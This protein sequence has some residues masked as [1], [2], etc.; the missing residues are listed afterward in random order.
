VQVA[1]LA[2]RQ[3]GVVSRAQL[4]EMGLARG[5][6]DGRLA[7]GRLHPMHGVYLVG[8]RALPPLAREA[9]ALLAVGAAGALSHHAAA[10]LHQFGPTPHPPLDVAVPVSHRGRRRDL[11]LRRLSLDAEEVTRR[12]GLRATT[13]ARTLL[14]L[15]AVTTPGRLERLMAEAFAQRHT[16]R[17]A[18]L[19]AMDG[20]PGA[21]GTRVLRNLLQAGPADTRSHPERR[22][23]QILRASRLPAPE[24]NVRLGPWTP[25]FL[26]RAHGLA[27]EVDGYAAHSSPWA[28]ERDH[29]KRLALRAQGLDVLAFTA[30]QVDDEPYVVLAEIARAPTSGSS[31]PRSPER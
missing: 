1:R 7:R 18:L 24:V 11:R 17:E 23:V 16:S 4:V 10:A 20:H 5:A 12:H 25:D 8:H 22:L 3:H 27:V 13:P 9:A 19:R 6:I 21:R 14:D 15:A 31:A 28:H 29:R 26:W 2:E 30:R